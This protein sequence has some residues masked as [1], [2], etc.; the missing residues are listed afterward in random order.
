VRA[1]LIENFESCG[2]TIKL[3]KD[4]AHHFFNVL[5]LKAGTDVLVLDGRGKVAK[6]RIKSLGKRHG[7]LEVLHIENKIRSKEL[8]DVALGLVKK[9]ALDSCLKSCVELGVDTI[10]LMK[11]EYSQVY[12][13]KEERVNNILTGACEQSNNPFMPEVE[14][15]EMNELLTK[16]YDLIFMGDMRPSQKIKCVK[17]Q[18]ILVL[19]GPEGGFSPREQDF[20]SL[21][22]D[23]ISINLGENILR[24]RTAV[25]ALIGHIRAL[26]NL[27]A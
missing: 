21:R 2:G 22:S 15:I 18:K 8:L 5:K 23:L 11:T 10:Y 7:Q 1:V 20:L 9:E 26:E 24:T 14:F 27:D 16:P 6:S 4:Q 13:V 25:P 19:V 17:A 12:K 3:E